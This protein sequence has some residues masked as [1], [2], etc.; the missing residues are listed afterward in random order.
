MVVSK[1]FLIVSR[2]CLGTREWTTK[3]VWGM[4]ADWAIVRN[5]VPV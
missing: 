1:V 2:S 4:E 3:S 5:F